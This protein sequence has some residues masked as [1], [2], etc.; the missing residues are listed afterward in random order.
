METQEELKIGIG[1]EEVITLKPT[2]VKIMEVRIEEVG[3]TK[4]AKKVICACKHPDALDT[5]QISAVKY[6]TKG[7]LETVGLWVNKDSKGLIRKG[8][9]LAVFLN[10]SGANTVEEVKG[11]EIATTT[12]DKNYLVFKG[13]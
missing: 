13:Y 8:S 1:N 7:K 2:I 3:T 6:E 10:F 5:I 12:D 11:K 9:A 4:K